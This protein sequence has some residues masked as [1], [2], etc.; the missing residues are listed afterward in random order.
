MRILA[1]GMVLAAVW[2]GAWAVLPAENAISWLVLF[3]GGLA[4]PFAPYFIADWL[5]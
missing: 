3:A 2:A 4:V 1:I 5:D